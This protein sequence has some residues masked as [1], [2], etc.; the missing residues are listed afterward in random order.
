[1]VRQRDFTRS[2]DGA[3]AD[4]TGVADRVVGAT[5]RARTQERLA[6][7]ELAHSRVDARRFEALVGGQRRENGRQSP[8]CQHRFAR[9]RRQPSMMTLL[10][11]PAA[12]TTTLALGELL[13]LHVAEVDRIPVQFLDFVRR[14][15]N[16]VDWRESGDDADRLRERPDAEHLDL[17]H[18]RR[19]A[20]VGG[21]NEQSRDAAGRELPSPSTALRPPAARSRRVPTPPQE[22]TSRTCPPRFASSRRADP[23]RWA[24]RTRSAS[25][26]RSAGEVNARRVLA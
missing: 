18:D 22:R 23:V 21:R 9:T 15:R 19:F 7:P 5:D 6:R 14:G 12:A 1:M 11:A 13:T 3:A 24:D 10:A 2:R 25:L 8:R 26:R 16:G 20:G 4:H 17:A